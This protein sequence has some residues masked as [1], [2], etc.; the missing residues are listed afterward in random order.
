MVSYLTF[1]R[2]LQIVSLKKMY[3]NDGTKIFIFLRD[4]RR[5]FK[6]KVILTSFQLYVVDLS[7]ELC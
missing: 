6:S 4:F 7:D 5:N 2:S 1:I 3:D